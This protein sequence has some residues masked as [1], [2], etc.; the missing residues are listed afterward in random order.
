[1]VRGATS[2]VEGTRLQVE[3]HSSSHDDTIY[4]EA[5]HCPD[6]RHT[7]VVVGVRRY[8]HTPAAAVPASSPARLPVVYL[9]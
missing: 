8:N 1:M 7:D 6:G 9:A 3:V 4:K 5:Y 2:L